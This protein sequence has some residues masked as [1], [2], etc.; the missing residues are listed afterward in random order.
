MEAGIDLMRLECLESL[1]YKTR[2]RLLEKKYKLIKR[3]ANNSIYLANMTS[4]L[5]QIHHIGSPFN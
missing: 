3:S 1:D 4:I 5:F 2:D